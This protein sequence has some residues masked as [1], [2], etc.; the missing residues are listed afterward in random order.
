MIPML[1][2]THGVD[3]TRWQILFYTV[4][5]V[6]VTVLP[7]IT[8][9]SG[10]FYL[11]GALVLGGV[12]LYYAVRLMNPPDEAV[13][14]AGVQLFD[15]VPDG[16]VRLPADRPLADAVRARALGAGARVHAQRQLI[17][18]APALSD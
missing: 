1:P 9:M 13:R 18:A 11:G 14:D 3:Y 8:G 6:L 7:W 16:A 17:G 2:V 10:L 4:L 5:L 15:L 12:F